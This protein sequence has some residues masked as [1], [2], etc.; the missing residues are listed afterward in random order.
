MPNSVPSSLNGWWSDYKSEIGFLGF[1]YA[2]DGCQSA[3]TL[4]SEFKD[5]RKRFHG[6]YVRLYGA[7]DRNGFYDDVVDAAWDAGLG[8][9]ALIWFGFDGSD[10]W[11][12][13][14]DSLFATLHSNPKAKFVTR[15]VQ[16]GSEPLFDHVLPP[17]T[18]ASQVKS[19]KQNLAPLGILVTV[20]D[21]AYGY[22]SNGGAQSVLDAVDFVDLHM[23]P[24]FSTTATTADASWGF[25]QND[26]KWINSKVHGKKII[27][28]ENGWP[29]MQS[30]STRSSSPTAV[31]DVQQEQAYF[32]LLDSKCE[33]FKN[34]PGGG[35]GW[36]AHLY[37]EEQGAGYG[38]LD[39]GKL[40]FP[41]S[42]RTSC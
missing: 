7:C 13:R 19:A 2:V 28:S 38:I 18:L 30:G 3:S 40:K 12:T 31:A 8:V 22:Q 37:S 24:F 1:S 34:N 41:F 42:P 10:V 16:F 20:S 15:A 9:H 26:L 23:L 17:D 6:R 36:F 5:I 39:N 11:K 29:S 33:V 4:K 27:L 21:M 14:R 35:V 25:V 32:D